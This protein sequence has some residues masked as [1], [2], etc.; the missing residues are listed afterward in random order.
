MERI[1]REHEELSQE[2]RRFRAE[3][4]EQEAERNEQYEA[5][6]KKIVQQQSVDHEKIH[7][8]NKQI[9][10]QENKSEVLEKENTILL[11]R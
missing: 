3:K 5:L 11:L 10:E 2:F 8:L 7:Q 4:E 6:E 9:D 1:Q